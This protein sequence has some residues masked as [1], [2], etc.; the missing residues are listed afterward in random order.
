VLQAARSVAYKWISELGSRLDKTDDEISRTELGRRLCTLAATC[1]STYSVFPK[2]VPW[3]L[4]NED[5]AIA[6]NCAVI[7]H[8]NTPPTLKDDASGYLSRLLNRHRRLLHYLEP[9][10]Q[11]VIQSNPTGFD[12]GIAKLWPEFRRMSS[13]WQIL[14]S[15]NS[16]WISCTVG[17]GQEVHYNL[18]SG[19][20]L[21]GGKPLGRLPQEITNH[22]TYACVLGTVSVVAIIIPASSRVLM[23][24]FQRILDVIPADKPGMEF[25][26]R[27]NV[28]GYQVGYHNRRCWQRL[29]QLEAKA[30]LFAT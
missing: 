5:I 18:L 28:S 10:F 30:V 27:S 29:I 4:S 12:D 25:M 8:D 7:V 2:H 6:L 11:E 9:F 3:I 1:F 14:P 23:C 16:R 24:P 19:K 20:L 15:P 26:T 13:D 21:I 17:G 22:S